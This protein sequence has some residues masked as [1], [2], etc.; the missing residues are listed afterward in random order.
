MEFIVGLLSLVLAGNV[1]IIRLSFFL[2]GSIYCIIIIFYVVIAIS[3]V[4]YRILYIFP[5]K[6]PSPYFSFSH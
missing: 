4:R 6:Y 3:I 5:I 1:I 2:N